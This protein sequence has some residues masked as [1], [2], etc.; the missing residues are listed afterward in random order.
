MP[1]PR[2]GFRLATVVPAVLAGLL[3]GTLQAAAAPAPP[4]PEPASSGAASDTPWSGSRG[5]DAPE[6]RP[7]AAEA[8]IPEKKRD[9]TLGP[10][11]RTSH[12]RMWTT[13]GDAR[14]MHLL[15]ADERS[16][17]AWRTAATL[18]EP[19]FDTDAWIGN[20]CVTASGKRA[21]VVYA[22]RTFTNKAELFS[23]G[24]FA[25]VVDLTTG[26]VTKLRRQV[27]LA[28]YNPGCGAGEEAILT[29]SGGEDKSSTR[30]LRVDAATGKVAEPVEVTGQLTSAVPAGG[31]RI[32]A[33]DTSRIVSVAADGRRSTLAATDAVPFRLTPDQDGGLTFLDRSGDRATARH[34]T[35]G[36]LKS[37]ASRRTASPLGHGKLDAVDVTRSADGRVYLSGTAR[38]GVTG[39][40]PKAVRLLDAPPGARVST[41][42]R[43]V[44]TSAAWTDGKD[45]RVTAEAAADPR[46]VT[47]GV[48]L[49]ARGR[50]MTFVVDPAAV[51]G[52]DAGQGV[53]PTPGLGTGTGTA[54]KGQATSSLATAAS[55][56]DPVEDE[57]YCSVPRN[58]PRNQ[59]MQPKPRQVEWA[60]D[61]AIMGTLNAKASRPANW[62][63]LG[64]PAYA[65]QTLFPKRTLV[66]G[67]H[68][69]A[70]VMLGV[71]AQES[72]MWQA[73]RFAVPGV[74]AN[75]LIGNY[76]GLEIYNSSSADDWDINWAEADCG[77]GITQVTDHMRLAGKEKGPSDTAWAYQTQRA[78][79]LD[80]VVNVAAG[81]QILTDK[82]NQT[83]S[84][85]MK[86]NN[87]DATK[88]E[89][90]FF[91]LWAYNSGFYPQADSSKNGGAWG[92]G[93]AN[94]PANP[95]YPAN[96]A[97]FMDTSY[98]DAAHPQ[99]WPYP[100]KVIGFAG[101]PPELLEAPN[102]PVSAYRPAWWNGDVVTAP[103]NRA[104][105]KPPVNQFCDASNTCEP[106][107]SYTP[108]APEV[109]GAKAGPCAHKNASGQYD[110]KCWY[111]Q[112]TTWKSDCSYS[113]GNELVRF[114]STYD[115]QADG[116]PYPP[117][118]STAGLPSGA[119]VIDDL[120]DGTPSVRPGCTTPTSN[121]G[122]FALNF[123][124]DSKGLYPSK[125]DF[126][127]LGA[128]YGGHFSFA[129]TRQASAEGG[130]MK[131]TGTWT[132][133]KT[134]SQ[135]ARVLVHLPDHGAQTQLAQYDVTTKTGVRSRIVRQPG[136]GNRWVSIGAFM[137]DNVPKVTLSS[138]TSD[139]TGD[140]D[141]AYDAVAFVPIT[142]TYVERSV[143]AVALFD[144]DQNLDTSAPA[145][146]IGGPLTSR[147]NLYDWAMDLTGRITSLPSCTAGPT[148]GCAMPATKSAMTAWRSQ[149]T[150][151]GTD[152]VNHPD[153]TSQGTWVGFANPYT[154]RPTS[155]TK[156][157]RFD[158][159]DNSYK[160][161]SRTTVSFVKDAAGTVI[162]GSEYVDY[163]NRTGNTHLPK[164][165]LDTF[166]ALATDYG[167]A[168]PDLRYSVKNLNQHDNKSHA[169]DPLAT[170]V[171]PGRSYAFAGKK[172]TVVK[173]DDTPVETG[174]TC[175]ATLYAS[176]GS[177][178]YRP[179]LSA[180]APK[181]N[182]D[183]WQKK[184][185]GDSR[186]PDAVA[187]LA[188]GIW[189]NFFQTEL[190]S[191][192]VGTAFG[193][194]PPIW[195]E[196]SLKVC[197]DGSVRK[198][199]GRPYLRSS[200]MPDQYLYVDGKAM[201]LDG[202]AGG[203]AP[204]IKGDFQDFS[205]IPDP[206]QDYP[207]WPNPYGPC[208]FGT[209]QSGNPWDITAPA[210]A[211]TDPSPA[212][213]CLDKSI[214]LDAGYSSY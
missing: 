44:I 33:A 122:N 14:G 120:P 72:N 63:N 5:A 214:P 113:C 181:Q 176:G 198:V 142:G 3:A 25:A 62:K 89:N 78:V 194:A 171:L 99:D 160:I 31:G 17:Y 137:F 166:S 195:Q 156:P 93:W 68:V 96:R 81:L 35:A 130:K 47:L 210:S 178:G 87:G 108:N 48:S 86:I 186:V 100:E 34:L 143:D 179:M 76:Y 37:P 117:N 59:A 154:D 41:T 135:P 205:K 13:T 102:T 4:G 155:S 138:V 161:R 184:A 64:M 133:N 67:D 174:G 128:G 146:W 21:V 119:L 180:D 112:S 200:H 57:R 2:G 38:K 150:A 98:A 7:D 191:P 106:G 91:A 71:T 168:R 151:A 163:G 121:Q 75:P 42:G 147:Q 83:R 65:P 26:D 182:I 111:H 10:G 123:A 211:G 144:E 188:S 197:A 18:A 49:P 201:N 52:S 51:V 40:L 124:A 97:S 175:V 8:G 9:A 24:A 32:V 45:S 30:L 167:I 185:D 204:V 23:R 77:Y 28:Y 148:T 12:D 153:G 134:L 132:L 209:D 116:T 53:A 193:Q 50:T 213:F 149:V 101:H 157:T 189:S 39:A 29:Q 208:N 110:L 58:D 131:V 145:S 109:A 192:L 19:G 115:E 187:D 104:N 66:E 20:A 172:P 56:S 139:G 46:P 125:I 203:A 196:L 92:V 158:T 88:I 43:A 169:A 207:L 22:P 36:Q 79:A 27:S 190:L 90:W 159:D 141:I 107:K 165:M 118:C 55:P 11:W 105:A 61:Q 80:Y 73:A 162:P 183:N 164:F 15:V 114:N 54:K 177:I 69:P 94:N 6:R 60:V 82:W 103:L 129:H 206:N 140:D 152:P 170:G 70:Q 126:H 16:G 136:N 173:D 1:R 74:T 85:G 212:H 199:S 202:G 84:A 127:Q 95:E